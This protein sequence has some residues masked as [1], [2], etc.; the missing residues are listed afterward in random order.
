VNP[1][2]S[3]EMV[4]ERR[5]DLETMATNGRIRRRRRYVVRAFGV[6]LIRAGIRLADPAD[7]TGLLVVPSRP[8]L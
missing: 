2:L 1:S 5:R 8:P 7:V 3:A 6:G 4:A